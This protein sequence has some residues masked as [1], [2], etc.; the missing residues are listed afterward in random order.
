MKGLFKNTRF[1]IGQEISMKIDK[2]N[3]VNQET[4]FKPVF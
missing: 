3:L 4:F 2:I 1:E